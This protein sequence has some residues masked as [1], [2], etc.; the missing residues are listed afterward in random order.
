MTT[1]NT[2]NHLWPDGTSAVV[3]TFDRWKMIY[4][5]DSRGERECAICGSTDQSAL[6][7]LVGDP[8]EDVTD[9]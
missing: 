2:C 6:E 8:P 5:T 1:N 9:D 3:W 4:G 7:D